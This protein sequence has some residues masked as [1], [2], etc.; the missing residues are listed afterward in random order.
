LKLVAMM[1]LPLS[2]AGFGDIGFVAAK[3]VDR[4]RQKS[5]LAIGCRY[6][7][8]VFYIELQRTSR[9]GEEEYIHACCSSC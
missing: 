7:L 2:G 1:L 6:F 9:L 8:S 5:R 3:K 4:I